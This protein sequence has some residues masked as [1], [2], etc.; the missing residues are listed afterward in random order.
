MHAERTRANA[1]LCRRLLRGVQAGAGRQASRRNKNY[2]TKYDM[3]AAPG[4]A[5][6]W[7]ILYPLTL[8]ALGLL[9]VAD[10]GLCGH[11]GASHAEEEHAH[12]MNQ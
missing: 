3:S 4:V 8:A 5:A 6:R 7:H 11:P 10:S 1:T 12:N 2:A 9:S